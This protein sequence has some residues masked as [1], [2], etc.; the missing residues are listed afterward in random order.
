[1]GLHRPRGVCTQPISDVATARPSWQPAHT[2]VPP[3][4]PILTPP[5][6]PQ[7]SVPGAPA[8]AASSIAQLREALLLPHDGP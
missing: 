3:V 6:L 1:M 2:H 5:L 7:W 4:S 8:W